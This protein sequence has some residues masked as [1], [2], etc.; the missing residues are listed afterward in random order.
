M[1]SPI[2]FNFFF[3]IIPSTDEMKR[4]WE[5]EN[6][7]F[8]RCSLIMNTQHIWDVSNP[9]VHIQRYLYAF[10]FL[11]TTTAWHYRKNAWL[12]HSFFLCSF[13][14]PQMH[15]LCELER[16]S[17]QLK[18]KKNFIARLI[19]III[20]AAIFPQ[21]SSGCILSRERETNY[22]FDIF[23]HNSKWVRCS[24]FYRILSDVV[25]GWTFITFHINIIVP[26]F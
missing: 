21:L 23:S 25:K 9:R 17:I 22:I 19:I 11:Y 1:S 15:T 24:W 3:S 4:W 6:W 26:Q 14:R 2:E 8:L 20:T 18:R 12:A 5:A 7:I 13:E 16:N 10:V